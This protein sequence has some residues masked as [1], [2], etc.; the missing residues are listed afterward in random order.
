MTTIR[1]V[2]EWLVLLSGT[3]Q[4][5]QAVTRPLAAAPAGTTSAVQDSSA[6]HDS[7]DCISGQFL[8][9]HDHHFIES[10]ENLH[11]RRPVPLFVPFGFCAT[12]HDEGTA[13]DVTIGMRRHN[14]QAIKHERN[15]DLGFSLPK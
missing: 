12:T 5:V 13:S 10:K 6:N 1:S 2:L 14:Q 3:A 4:I 15:G 9:Y 7:T 11:F 8:F